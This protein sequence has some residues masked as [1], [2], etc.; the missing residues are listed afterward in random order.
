MLAL[1][2]AFV[3]M[4]GSGSAG[5]IVGGAPD[6]NGHPNVAAVVYDD[7]F[8][9]CTGVLV[10]PRIVLT[11]AHCIGVYDFLGFSPSGV[12]F[13]STVDETQ[14]IPLDGP[15][16]VDPGW[17]GIKQ[18]H[19]IAGFGLVGKNDIH[20]LAVL[21]L[22]ADAPPTA[23]P[24]TL[25]TEGLLDSL[26]AKGGLIGDPITAVGYGTTDP[27]V[28]PRFPAD[29]RL[30]T[31]TIQAVNPARLLVSISNGGACI[32]DS[33]GPALLSVEGHDIAVALNSLPTTDP[34]CRNLADYYRLDTTEAR[35]FLS[36]FLTLP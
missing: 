10:A 36:Q 17:P 33:G 14:T 30:A 26:A 20:D 31:S 1:V 25:P 11:A 22:A 9:G 24:A 28:F 5:A 8:V 7:L 18:F 16:I 2:C 12:S 4:L 23:V 32:A 15:P 34:N 27:A 6:G 21:R 3:V 19:Q 29:R 13:A 35:S